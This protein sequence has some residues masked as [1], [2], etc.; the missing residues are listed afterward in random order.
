MP[1]RNTRP[2]VWSPS[3]LS[4]AKDGTH[5]F[6]GA[7]SALSN[8]IP[9]SATPGT[10]ES[11]PA[12]EELSS[13]GQFAAPGQCSLWFVIGDLAYGMLPSGRFPGHDEPFIFN[14]MTRNFLPISGVI[15]ANLPQTQNS[16][17][18]WIAPTADSL[19]HY[20]TV[21]HPGFL[22]PQNGYVGWFDISD[23]TNPTWNSGNLSG[24]VT[25]PAPPALVKVYLGRAYWFVGNAAI[26]SDEQFPLRVTNGNQ[27]LTFGS[28]TPVTAVGGMPLQ[29]LLGGSLA[30]LFIFKEDEEGSTIYQL[31]GDYSGTPSPWNVVPLQVSGGTISQNSIASTPRGLAMIDHDGLRFLTLDGQLSDPVGL[32][33][34]GV[35]IAFQNAVWP[36]RICG[37]YNRSVYRVAVKNGAKD[38]NPWEEYWFHLKSGRWSGPHSF[39]PALIAPWKQSFVAVNVLSETFPGSAIW[40][41]DVKTSPVT[42]YIENGRRLRF[43]FATVLL[44]DNLLL[45]EN[46]VK[47]TNIEMQFIGTDTVATIT[48]ADA[49]GSW[50]GQVVIDPSKG[51][52]TIWGGFQ[53]GGAPWGSTGVS[54]TKWGTALW[55]GSNWTGDV[56][57]MA[58][59]Q[60]NWSQELVFRQMRL[61]VEGACSTG[62]KI[63]TLSVNLQVLGYQQQYATGVQ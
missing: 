32:D 49:G 18:D 45:R 60:I 48:A 62:F 50:L 8:L 58:P 20:V 44:P 7:M 38:T 5:V 9:D 15:G 21:T 11:R 33:G 57:P 13:F 47:E 1:L 42:S 10:W 40:R 12:A 26:A 6:R 61:V 28:S 16:Q 30:C 37:S 51:Q 17:G 46:A 14:L 2:V 43:K 41:S 35:T 23:P 27:V 31:T 55:L 24:A 25:F 54:G 53:W 19:S 3:G 59:W 4:D 29:T 52:Q 63:G 34:E 22:G 39:I 56:A 36:S